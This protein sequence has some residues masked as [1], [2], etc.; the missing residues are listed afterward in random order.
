MQLNGR[1]ARKLPSW[2]DRFVEHTEGI[3]TPKIFRK[4]AGIV[5]IASTLEQ[6]VW[7]TTSSPMY[8]NLYV[9]MIAQPGVGKTRIISEAGKLLQQ[10]P[11]P[12]LAPTSINSSSL[13]DHLVECKR[14]IIQ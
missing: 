14:I 1:G 9:G 11:E 13:V 3:E 5:T 2:I 7:I 6:K 12:Y 4:W 8:P 10:L